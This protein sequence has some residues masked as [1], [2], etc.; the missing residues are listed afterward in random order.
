MNEST[1]IVCSPGNTLSKVLD[2]YL[3]M[4][5]I[6]SKKYYSAYSVCA[7]EAWKDIF[8]N[9][10]YVQ[11]SSWQ[12]IKQDSDGK[13]YID[14]PSGI[15]RFFAVNTLDDCNNL[16]PIWYN[17]Q[18]NVIPTPKKSTCGC[19]CN[20]GGI[21]D[22]ANSTIMTTRLLFT[23]SG[24]QYFEK[25]WTEYC[26]NGDIIE[27]KETPVKNY[28]DMIGS[29][30]DYNND[31]NNDFLIGYDGFQNFK[32]TYITSQKVIC[33][34][35]TKPCGCPEET[36]ENA[37]CF[38]SACGSH[39]NFCCSKTKCYPI[40][41]D[42]NNSGFGEVKFSDCGTRI[43]WKPSK[44]HWEK[45]RDKLTH[46]QVSYQVSGETY[47]SEVVIPEMANRCMYAGIDY[48]SKIYN[49]K[50][51][52]F[53]KKAA[54]YKFENEKI[55]LIQFLNPVSLKFIKNIQDAPILW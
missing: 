2:R 38:Y 21:C 3:I 55:D 40:F 48:F 20:C 45:N 46:I 34:L 14:V 54:E 13:L 50:V 22:D 15:V 32:I 36:E 9:T 4:R 10:I 47:N 31:Y 18:M 30:G 27:Y 6:Q 39:L 53:E 19:G 7:M 26:K 51:S 42:I 16:V 33:K 12:E 37:A 24:V 5:Q 35:K 44:I 29:T 11:A 28:G 43:Y 1:Q 8:Q 41:S 23:I 49:G 25:T 17:S 52:Y